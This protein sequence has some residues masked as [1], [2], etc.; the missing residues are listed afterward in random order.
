M[1]TTGMVNAQPN[2]CKERRATRTATPFTE[3][4]FEYSEANWNECQLREA[5]IGQC[6]RYLS[7]N[8]LSILR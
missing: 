3:Y 4:T 7:K 1:V 5:I 2:M 6:R 8:G